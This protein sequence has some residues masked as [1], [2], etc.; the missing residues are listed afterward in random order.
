VFQQSYT[1]FEVIVTDDSRTTVVE[2]AVNTWRGDRRLRYVR[3]ETRLGSPENW[4]HAVALATG[5]LIKIL[6]HDDWFA[7]EHSLQRFV[8]LLENQPDAMFAFA[9]AYARDSVGSVLFRH[10]ATEKQIAALRK[11]PRCLLF[12][13]FVGGPSATI[14]RREPSFRFDRTLKWLVDVEAYIRILKGGRRFAFTTEP[15]V[16]ITAAG[17]HQVT[18]VIERNPA[19]QFAE[20]AYV[21]RGLDFGPIKRLR[22]FK[23]FFRLAR[24]L[25]LSAI[26][27]VQMKPIAAGFPLEVRLS[28]AL[29][30][31]RLVLKRRL[32]GDAGGTAQH[33]A[34]ATAPKLSYSQCGEDVIIDFIFMW[35]GRNEITYLDIGAHHPTWLS[36]TYFFYRKGCKGVLIEPDPEMAAKL[37]SMR[38]RDRC[39]QVAVGVDGNATAKMYVMSS[40]TLNTL[41]SKQADEYK[42]YGREQV[43]RVIEVPQRG[44]NE[45][46]V[47]EFEESPNLVS[48][49]VEGLD[50]EILRNWDFTQ[51]R[52][53]VF[54]VETLTF[55]QNATERK[56]SDIVDFMKAHDYFPYA[57]TYINTIFVSSKSWRSRGQASKATPT[58]GEAT[59][60]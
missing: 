43:E 52:P 33:D 16:N 17:A 15:L 20:N 36:N 22:C 53:E 11:D 9:G 44:I 4:N 3:N 60:T 6:H 12:G 49:D 50:L 8:S 32:G 46:L 47:A 10:A 31:L 30:K 29:Q 1:D 59:C 55:T 2:S 40:R 41:L 42:S 27:V 14:F 58:L 7:S 18:R 13:N 48:L 51:F 39:L 21:Y 34:S 45:I 37:V 54:C 5:H 25:D 19:L 26:T 57:D 56:L 24:R 38:P 35:L 28:M 23:F